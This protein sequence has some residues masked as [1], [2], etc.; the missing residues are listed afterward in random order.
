MLNTQA[1]S[2]AGMLGP[3]RRAVDRAA[4]RIR[5]H[6]VAEGRAGARALDL[7]SAPEESAAI[8][9]AECRRLPVGSPSLRRLIA[10]LHRS[11]A[12]DRIVDGLAV[13]D[14]E[15]QLR[16]VRLS[17]ALRLEAAVPWLEPLLGSSHEPLR[18]AAARALGRI[19]GVRAAN[20]LVRGLGWRRGST[21]RLVME[22]ARAVPD[23]Y[24][25]TKLVDP[26]RLR[27]QPGSA[28]GG[29]R[30]RPCSPF[31]RLGAGPSAR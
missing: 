8:L 18:A 16:S 28:G 27:W 21:A 31:S 9:A 15:L 19:G 24:L 11:G 23:L 30:S 6:Q 17:G 29:R 10:G 3:V 13:R 1:P 2:A 20:A 26:G 4:F 5:L 25:E 7:G 14:R 22:L 12:L